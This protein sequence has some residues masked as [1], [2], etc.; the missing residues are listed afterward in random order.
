MYYKIK[1]GSVTLSGNTILENICFTVTDNEKI[2]I[3]G[4]NG[5]GK[6]TL[7]KAITNEIEL[8][9]GY[10]LL[11]VEKTDFKIGYSRQNIDYS[12]DELMIDFILESYKD[13][14]EV[15]AKIEKLSEKISTK[16]NAHD[17]DLYNDL[18]IKYEYMGGNTYKKEY[19]I[20]LKKFGFSDS[21][22]NKKMK[23]FSLGQVT[24]LSLIRLLLSKPDLLI[25]DEPTNHLDI[26]TIEWLEEYLRNYSKSIIV[27]SHDRMFLDNVCNVIYDIS[28][29]ELKR[30]SGNY[31]YYLKKKK[32]D[33][34][35]NLKDYIM[36][37]KE[38]KR[39]QAIADRFRYKPSKAKMAMSKLKQIERMDIIDKPNKDNEKTFKINFD[40]ALTSYSDVL[41]VKNLK[42]GYDKV[43]ADV[44]FNVS[45]GDKLGIIGANG[46][47][48]STLI[49]T[50]IKEIDPLG[51]KFVF[52][53]KVV[54]GYFSQKLDNISPSNTIY[55][56]IENTFPNMSMNEIRSLLGA[57]DFTKDDV[58]KK[59]STLSGG[60]KVR[61]SL[62]KILNTRPNVLILDEPT[63]HL[64]IIS[65]NRIE[66]MLKNYKGTIIMV[67]HDRYLIK[68]V[69]NK[70]LVF[71]PIDVTL[72]NYGYDEYLK[73]RSIGVVD[74][75]IKET[76]KEKEMP[77]EKKVSNNKIKQIEKE[78]NNL[79]T[80][81][82][83]L[84]K[85][86]LKEEIYLDMFKSNSIQKEIDD[87]E[88]TVEEKMTLWEEIQ[89]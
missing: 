72:Y 37:Q 67:S 48:K 69:C 81:I 84:K 54:I 5:T 16:Y 13:I 8:E 24:K 6:T 21:D 53:E 85:E 30:Y 41:K 88:S 78:I 51:G 32:E 74:T 3:V 15:E 61:V 60:E 77:K 29:G 18:F 86:L 68:N 43:L 47:G 22:K 57:F 33:Y 4:R 23:E 17:L 2:G 49:K 52:G 66:E 34:D 75:L 28:Y 55:E 39:L 73:K 9:D 62:C 65:K 87:L 12:D 56:E 89:K 7:L 19:E 79:E 40:P 20:A 83:T 10:D 71:S 50:L 25:L 42:V 11:E 63:N 70:L 46:I 64:D 36:Q 59:I 26:T 80:K 31:T 45:R 27:V 35:R 44:T 38:I 58:F 14:L 76:K 82:S 1:N